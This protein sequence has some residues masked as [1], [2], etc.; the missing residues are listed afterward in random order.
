VAAKPI[1]ITLNFSKK[2]L[3]ALFAISIDFQQVELARLPLEHDLKDQ[4][5]Y[6]SFS[7]MFGNTFIP[8]SMYYFYYPNL[9]SDAYN[10]QYLLGKTVFRWDGMGKDGASL[11]YRITTCFK[12]NWK[13]FWNT[14]TSKVNEEYKTVDLEIVSLFVWV[15]LVES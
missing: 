15:R 11:G 7:C 10:V 14:T 8:F 1:Y 4:A 13:C 3:S 12:D 5:E 9:L 2:G 6:S